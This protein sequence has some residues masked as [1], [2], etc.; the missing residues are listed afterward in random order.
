VGVYEAGVLFHEFGHVLDMTIG[1]RRGVAL[2]DGWWGMDWVEGPSFCLEYWGR[3]A[4][5]FATYA[6]HPESGEPAPAAAVE[7]LGVAL[8]LEDVTYVSKYLM[9]GLLD[10]AVHGA[11][12]VDLDAAWRTAFAATPLPEPVG[13]FRPFPMSMVTGGYDAALYGVCYA[14]EIRD[15]LLA[16]FEREGP[17]N[18]AVGRR[19]VE[20]VLRPGPFV[21]P[22]ERLA[23]FLGRPVSASSLIG[24][25][26]AVVE[27]ARRASG[28]HAGS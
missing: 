15:E 23:A 27:T 24:R 6:R 11:D 17:L 19:Y 1:S 4:E 9:L 21:P 10:L 16:A 20:R 8:G 7:A 12:E 13:G 5:V 28:G 14:L 3:S 25:L 2:D 26:E 18:P 22:T